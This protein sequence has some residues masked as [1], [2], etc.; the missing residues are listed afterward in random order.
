MGR[1]WNG[2]T[3]AYMLGT[4]V[5][6]VAEIRSD[7]GALVDPTGLA[8]TV[9]DDAGEKTPYTYPHAAITRLG[10]GLYR[11]IITPEQ[12]GFYQYRFASTGVGQTAGEGSF[13]IHPS[14][15]M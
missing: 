5:K 12:P 6:I 2:T 8:F 4:P 3:R 10:T 9:I 15:F 1:S 14:D 7:E 11:F 13:H